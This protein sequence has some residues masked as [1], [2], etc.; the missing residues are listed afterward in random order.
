[1]MEIDFRDVYDIEDPNHGV[2]IK[3]LYELLKEREGAY[4]V[5]ISH[6]ELPT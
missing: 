1:M 2:Y 6:K 4:K 5:N 3:A